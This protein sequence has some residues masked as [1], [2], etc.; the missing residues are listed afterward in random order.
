[1]YEFWVTHHQ[2]CC[3][4]LPKWMPQWSGIKI[5][6]RNVALVS[7]LKLKTSKLSQTINFTITLSLV[8]V[9]LS[10]NVASPDSVA[11]FRSYLEERWQFVKL[12]HKISDPK[13]VRQE[14]PLGSILGP[15]LFLLFVNDMPWHLNNLTID[16]HA[17]DT[18]LSLSAN[19]N[20]ITSLT[21]YSITQYREMVNWKQNVR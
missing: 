17:D 6:H 1:M 5:K 8:K 21:Q 15:V 11:W 10:E 14:V 3:Q 16:I 4:I 19:W 20:N 2:N 12:G 9:K 7:T 13:P 18:T